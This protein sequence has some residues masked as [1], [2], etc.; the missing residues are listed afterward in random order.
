MFFLK[1]HLKPNSGDRLFCVVKN[2]IYSCILHILQSN[3]TLI[4]E[5]NIENI[6]SH[7]FYSLINIISLV[8]T[9]L[10]YF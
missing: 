3:F 1:L 5:K 7:H 4:P 10:Y 9:N 8:I 2:E 6:K